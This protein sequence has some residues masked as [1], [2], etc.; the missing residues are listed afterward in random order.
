VAVSDIRDGWFS[1][2]V[3]VRV[4]PGFISWLT[5]FGDDAEVIAPDSL[6]NE[7]KAMIGS[8]SRVYNN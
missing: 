3:N 7:M 6:K 4:S 1:I 2:S 5:I 8:L